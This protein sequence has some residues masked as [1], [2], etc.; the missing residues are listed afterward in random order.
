MRGPDGSF[1]LVERSMPERSLAL[2]KPEQVVLNLFVDQDLTQGISG[3]LS[4]PLL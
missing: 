3:P 4:G 1:A 2:F